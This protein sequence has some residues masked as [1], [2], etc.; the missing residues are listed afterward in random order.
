MRGVFIFSLF[1]LHFNSYS[2]DYGGDKIG[3]GNYVRRMYQSQ[4]FNGVKLLQTQEG[5]E[6][7]VSVVEVKKDPSKSE[8]I[9]SRIAIVKAKAYASQY[10]NGSNVNSEVIIVTTEEKAKDSIITKTTM[11]EVLKESSV[12]FVDGIEFLTKFDSINN[13]QIIYVYYKK[14]K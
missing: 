1:L 12:G 11:Q 7:M 14:M 10:I 8:S 2:Q 9:Q 13:N 4:S 5:H 6:Y 3:I